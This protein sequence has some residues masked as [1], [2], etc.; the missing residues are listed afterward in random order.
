MDRRRFLAS[1]AVALGGCR[2]KRSSGFAGY[3][4]VANEEGH[5]VAAV[6]L[7]A[8][9]VAKHIRL[10]DAPTAVIGHPE[11]PLV[12]ALTPR[13]GTIHEIDAGTLAVKRNVQIAPS[14]VGMRLDPEAQ[15]LWVLSREMK[16]LL[17]VPMDELRADAAMSLPQD[18]LDFDVSRY[19]GLAAVSYS[20]GVSLIDRE[21]GTVSSP[22]RI[23]EEI[24][25]ARF[26]S[27]GKA[28]LVANTAA[29]M[30]TV[31]D[32]STT[33]VVAHLPLAVRPDQFCFNRDGGQLF[34]TGEGRDAVVVVY[35][36]YVPEVAETVLA[37]STPG[38][39]AVSE[40]HLFVANPQAGDVCILNI[41]RRKVVALAGVGAE[42]GYIAITPGDE[43]ALVLNRASGDMAVIRIPGIVPDRR[44]T[45]ALFTMIP[46]GSKPVSAVVVS[47]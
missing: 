22:V 6:D 31:L 14:A 27:D 4:F 39:M 7:T 24:G 35:P 42:P 28:L 45:A 32:T 36:Y 3:A 21:A 25:I 9:A 33:R 34:I 2:K 20:S 13:S 29:R 40:D 5:A 38:A 26:R 47:A 17:R 41:R 23:G 16:K 8:F 43:Y 30:L 1:T 12:Y 37:G 18:P 46:V 11:K 15:A 44:K 19:S 10:D